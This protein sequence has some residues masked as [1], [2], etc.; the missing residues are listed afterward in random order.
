MDNLHEYCRAVAENAKS[1]SRALAAVS[2][3]KKNA[4]LEL[5]A[6]KLLERRDEILAENAKDL[7]A[8]RDAGLKA[9]LIDRLTLSDKTLESMATALREIAAFPDPIGA[10]VGS[11][12]RP[13]GVKIQKV[14]VPIGVV[15]F[16][17]ESRP[18]V[19]TDAAAICVKSGNAVILRGG[20][21]AF[22]SNI[23]L[24]RVL[25]DAAAEIGLP[26]GAVQLLNTT[27]RDAVDEFL[28]LPRFV[29]VAIPR[30]GKSLIERVVNEAKMPVIKHFEGNCHVYVDQFADLEIAKKVLV[31]SKCQRLGTCNTAE[32]L[33][34]H[35][36]V[37]PAALPALLEAL[38]ANGVEIRGDERAKE[39]APNA[40]IVPAAPEDFYAE[41]L[42][43]IISVKIVDSIE[44]AIAHIN[45]HSS[46]HTEAIVSKDFAAIEKFTTE[47]DSASVMVNA[48]T[49]LHD[50]GQYGLGA[51]IGISTDKFHVR[52]PCGIAE[53]TS[54]KYVVYG[55]GAVRE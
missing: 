42:A 12:V 32:S 47:I 23:V 2:G 11:T 44:E 43:A 38:E 48:S 26:N 13:N 17:Y 35:S 50:G 49:R 8:A 45:E 9:S 51:E 21:E 16:I 46:G 55:D 15:F 4:W 30:G 14:R 5:C 41:Y 25:A 3:A 40:K 19:T 18:N 39:F 53:L 36:A 37:A 52:G 34:V 28:H 31:N 1:A 27:D 54:Y 7:D 24:G 20:K 29:D 33:V 6:A 22:H 10:T